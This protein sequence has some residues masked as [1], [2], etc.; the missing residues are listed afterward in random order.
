MLDGVVYTLERR[1]TS[2]MEDRGVIVNVVSWILLVAMV[3]VLFTRFAMKLACSPKGR[4][5]GTDDILIG[6][7]ALFSVGQTAAVS[8]EAIHALGQHRRDLTPKQLSIYQKSEYAACILYIANMGCARLSMCFLIRKILPGCAARWAVVIFGTFS[9]LWTIAGVLVSAFRC[10]P[11]NVWAKSGDQ[12]ID[13]VKFVNYTG[14]SNIVVEILLVSVPLFV[15]NL[16]T[17]AGRRVSVSACFLSRL[18]I[19]G[20]VAAQLTVYNKVA[21]TDDKT[22]EYWRSTICVQ[23]AQ[24][25]SIITA[26]IPCLHPF[27]LS[28]LNGSTKTD[29]LRFDQCPR[30]WSVRKIFGKATMRPRNH[31]FDSTSSYSSTF[32]I[33]SEKDTEYCRPLA[34]HGLD[35]STSRLDDR[36]NDFTRI[37]YNVATPIRGSEPPENVFNRSIEIPRSTSRPPTVH[38]NKDPLTFPAVKPARSKSQKSLPPIPPRTLEQVGVLPI[39]DWDSS[40]EGSSEGDSGRNSS[41]G[42]RTSSYIFNRET[43]ISVPEDNMA[44]FEKEYWRKYPPPPM[45]GEK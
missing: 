9:A 37:P 16:R 39:I 5:F 43:V 8:M 40:P 19:V 6:F 35:R 45:S 12:C 38:S 2:P 26:C 21:R 32:P 36:T 15:W 44:M 17:T 28:I 18:S 22:Y 7:A 23:V 3:F 29:S 13:I 24:N 10:K 20:A 33:Q 41:R 4:R 42:K 30:K 31:K 25:L 1:R 34:T 14:I 11:P 27:I